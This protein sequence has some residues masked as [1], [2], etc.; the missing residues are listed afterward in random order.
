MDRKMARNRLTTTYIL[1]FAKD[2]YPFR[3]TQPIPWELVRDVWIKFNETHKV[4]TLEAMES[5]YNRRFIAPV[6]AMGKAMAAKYRK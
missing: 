6:V 4:P 5:A 2:R 3:D 1:D